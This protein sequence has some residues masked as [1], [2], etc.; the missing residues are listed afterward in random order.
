[1][2]VSFKDVYNT[3]QPNI[4]MKTVLKQQKFSVNHR[5]KNKLKIDYFVVMCLI[6]FLYH[7]LNN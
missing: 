6:F 5:S 7:V 3:V 2:N 4:N 1:M